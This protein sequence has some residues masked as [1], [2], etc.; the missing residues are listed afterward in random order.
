MYWEPLQRCTQKR[1]Y[2]KTAKPIEMPFAVLMHV[3][4]GNHVLDEVEVG[5][6]HSPHEGLQDDDAAFC[7]DSLTIC[8]IVC[9]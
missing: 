5:R 7:Q 3:R 6:N 9:C 1:L 4:P 8:Y 2:V